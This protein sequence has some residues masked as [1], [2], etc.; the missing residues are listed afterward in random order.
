MKHLGQVPPDPE[1]DFELFDRVVNVRTLGVAPYGLKGT[2]VG[3]HQGTWSNFSRYVLSKKAEK[4]PSHSLFINSHPCF[5]R[6]Y[7]YMYYR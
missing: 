7:F 3:I 5:T 1:A 4:L 2:I 6:V